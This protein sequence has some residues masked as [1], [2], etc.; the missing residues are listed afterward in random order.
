MLHHLEVGTLILL[1]LK[2]IFSFSLFI[3]Y[4]KCIPFN[5]PLNQRE[6]GFD[7]PESL[8][9][10]VAR[11]GLVWPQQFLA[12]SITQT[13]M[14]YEDAFRPLHFGILIFVILCHDVCP[15]HCSSLSGASS[16]FSPWSRQTKTSP[17][18]ANQPRVQ[19][20]SAGLLQF[21]NDNK[22]NQ[23]CN[24]CSDALVIIIK[25]SSVPGETTLGRIHS[26]SHWNGK[27]PSLC[28]S[29]G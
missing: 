21:K 5:P 27:K 15:V 4:Q 29:G 13:D 9:R 18:T 6:H 14:I 25:E 12:F 22:N 20:E 11:I 19:W 2:L 1:G 17:D 3:Q 24:Q 8:Q 16:I 28:F 26:M 10:L 7:P 23:I